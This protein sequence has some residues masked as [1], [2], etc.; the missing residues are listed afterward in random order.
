MFYYTSVI[1]ILNYLFILFLFHIRYWCMNCV[2]VAIILHN[3]LIGWDD[4][5]ECFDQIDDDV[6][7]QT[8]V[9][10][11]NAEPYI[12]TETGEQ[13]RQQMFFTLRNNGVF[14]ELAMKQAKRRR[15]EAFIN[16]I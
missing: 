2:W 5:E 9:T 16:N 14:E 6:T 15:D 13:R 8:V 10:A 1:L 3:L 11:D 12:Q 4:G 7:F